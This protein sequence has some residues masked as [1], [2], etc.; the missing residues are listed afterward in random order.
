MR[1]A[2]DNAVRVVVREATV[3]A[4]GYETTKVPV[5]RSQA[6]I[7]KLL[8]AHGA[9][10]FAFAEEAADDVHYAVVAFTKISGGC[11]GLQAG[12]ESGFA[13]SGA[14]KADSPPGEPASP[15]ASPS[16]VSNR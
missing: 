6:E 10:R 12:E 16:A 2:G 3:R 4:M 7:R 8:T 1:R 5:E 14:G 11:P 9:T 15:A 13:R